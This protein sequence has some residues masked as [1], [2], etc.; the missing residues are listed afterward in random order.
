[1]SRHETDREDLML[2]ATAFT[3]RIELAVP[4]QS[5]SIVIGVKRNGAWSIYFGAEPVYQFD[6]SHRLR[7]AFTNGYLWR[8]QGTTL[9]RLERERT[10]SQTNL[11][12]HD[13]TPTELLDFLTSVRQRLSEFVSAWETGQ[14]HCLRQVPTDENL[15]PVILAALRSVLASGVELAPAV[16]GRL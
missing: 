2:E 15:E 1:M 4:L 16:K 3:Q 14:V 12:R 11:V 5:D 6:T 10:A 13:L 7:R 8:T 9:A